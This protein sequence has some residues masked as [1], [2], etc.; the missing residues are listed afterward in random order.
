MRRVGASSGSL[1]CDVPLGGW[2]PG[3][4]MVFALSLLV[5]AEASPS[6]KWMGVLPGDVGEGD[7]V[8]DLHRHPGLGAIAVVRP[9][10]GGCR[11]GGGGGGGGVRGVAHG[12]AA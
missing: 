10:G 7:D 4:L 11:V 5:H 12:V 9:R 1:R 2:R 8:S 6:L 3:I